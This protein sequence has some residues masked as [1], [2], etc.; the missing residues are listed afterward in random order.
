M[1]IKAGSVPWEVQKRHEYF[2]G[3]KLMYGALSIS[4]GKKG[5][6]LAFVGTINNQCSRVYSECK[7]GIKDKENIPLDVL[8]R[9]FLN[10]GRYYHKT[11][12][13]GPETI[14]LYREGLSDKQAQS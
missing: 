12:G 4:K 5:Y 7:T 14:I 13:A 3:R 9:I 2:K 1:N 8:Q 11:T 6:T 10:W